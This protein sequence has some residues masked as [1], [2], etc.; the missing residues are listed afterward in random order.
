MSKLVNFVRA[1]AATLGL[2]CLLGAL[3]WLAIQAGSNQQQAREQGLCLKAQARTGLFTG[4]AYTIYLRYTYQGH[5]YHNTLPSAKAITS[6]S[7][8]IKVLPANP[9][10][11]TWCETSN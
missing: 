1:N 5:S 11:I 7:V 6:D 9:D 8:R 4:T 3:L 10:A 2:F